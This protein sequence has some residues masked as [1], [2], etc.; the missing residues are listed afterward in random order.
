MCVC[1]QYICIYIHTYCLQY[2]DGGRAL[3]IKKAGATVNAAY[4][5][6]VSPDLQLDSQPPASHHGGPGSFQQC[7]VLIFICLLLSPERR[8]SE[9]WEP[10]KKQWCF[11]N[12]E[13]LDRNVHPFTPS[14]HSRFDS[15]ECKNA[16]THTH[17]TEG[18]TY[19]NPLDIFI[20]INVQDTQPYIQMWPH[21]HTHTHTHTHIYIYIYLDSRN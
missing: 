17:C 20:H 4:Q 18:Y 10:S 13:T 11:G 12:Q 2:R 16:S 6:F 1:I 14:V 8:T 21:T 19:V 5:G 3:E 15:P 9:A 7:S